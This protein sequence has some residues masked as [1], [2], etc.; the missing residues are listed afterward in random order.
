MTTLLSWDTAVL[1]RS[2]TNRSGLDQKGEFKKMT[3]FELTSENS[4]P[5]I[6]GKN[7]QFKWRGASGYESGVLQHTVGKVM[8]PYCL[9]TTN[10][11]VGAGTWA[12]SILNGEY[13]A[14][15]VGGNLSAIRSAKLVFNG[16]T[17]YSNDNLRHQVM[18]IRS[19]A[20]TNSQQALSVRGRQASWGMFDLESEVLS[21]NYELYPYNNNVYSTTASPASLTVAGL[22]GPSASIGMFAKYANEPRNRSRTGPLIGNE[23]LLSR[24]LAFHG[25]WYDQGTAG[26]SNVPGG[27]LE[28]L[29]EMR[30]R[31]T[32]ATLANVAGGD[33]AVAVD[34]IGIVS[35]GFIGIDLV[36]IFPIFADIPIGK[37]PS[38]ISMEFA[39]NN[40][41]NIQPTGGAPG[42]AGRSMSANAG[43]IETDG[44][45]PVVVSQH[46]CTQLADGLGFTGTTSLAGNIKTVN[47][48]FGALG[49]RAN[50]PFT[51]TGAV[52][53]HNPVGGEAEKCYLVMPQVTLMGTTVLNLMNGK[54]PETI[55]YWRGYSQLASVTK[56]IAP[57]STFVD[58]FISPCNNPV[59]LTYVFFKATG[60]SRNTP[61]GENG[62]DA[63]AGG[64]AYDYASQAI[65][66]LEPFFPTPGVSLQ[67]VSLIVENSLVVPEQKY[68]YEQ[69]FFN[70]RANTKNAR[71]DLFYLENY[72][73]A[74]A[75]S[76]WNAQQARPHVYDLT[77]REDF[78]DTMAPK[79]KFKAK[80]TSPFSVVYDR[81]VKNLMEI[82]L[83]FDGKNCIC[84][85]D[86]V[87]VFNFY[88]T[89]IDETPE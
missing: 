32:D 69:D 40:A 61:A 76:V 44:F 81:H 85:A 46:G 70:A 42:V 31:Y 52:V 78:I 82:T 9:M 73:V 59:E 60:P 29:K 4:G 8:V 5:Y 30:D 35:S 84:K 37:L 45:C 74:S 75:T 22:A 89:T 48:S 68:G 17:I 58:D 53:R 88:M 86:P 41:L 2:L 12:N 43:S 79:I 51:V 23:N 1:A 87:D 7:A 47:I 64:G 21:T 77:C 72:A 56:A 55:K 67:N 63:G 15:K 14:F 16:K 26:G 71:P 13:V 33:V 83:E 65:S 49:T 34:S 18:C 20:S 80:N 36:D 66:G 25:Q 54:L 28:Y 38:D 19:I 11:A 62:W 50:N 27:V 6:N 57:N 24:M 39:F 3:V 10:Q